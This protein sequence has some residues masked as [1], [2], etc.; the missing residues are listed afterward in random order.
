VSLADVL[1]LVRPSPKDKTR[2]ALYAWIRGATVQD[3]ERLVQKIRYKD[4]QTQEFVEKDRVHSFDDLPQRLK[5][6]EM[7]KSDPSGF[8]SPPK[9]PFQMLTSLDLGVEEWE[10]IAKNMSW[11]ELRQN[12]NT[13]QRH[14]VLANPRMSE[15]VCAKLSSSEEIL[16]AKCFPYQLLV[17]YLNTGPSPK[18]FG[19]TANYWQNAEADKGK[20]AD[21]ITV[22]KEV[23]YALE[24]AL[25]LA[26]KNVPT[27]DGKVFVCPDT[28]GSMGYPVTGDRGYYGKP[29][30]TK[31]RCVDVAG[32]MTAAILRRNPTAAA[33]PFNTRVHDIELNPMD[34]VM[35]NAARFSSL[36]G[37]GTACSEPLR[38]LNSLNAIG[39]VVIFVSDYESWAD[40]K[41]GSG[42]AMMQE[43]NRFKVRNPKAK[44][45]CVDITPHDNRQLLSHPDIM[46]VGGFSDQVFTMIDRFVKG[47][48]SA[49]HWT[50]EIKKIEV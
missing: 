40:T 3:G 44:L 25:E 7:Y 10:T 50:T 24:A 46:Y 16:K 39:D 11:Q 41:T 31:V 35:R 17:A 21:R 6:W 8:G 13:L 2:S 38:V 27:I 15:Y 32:L 4:R 22:P 36:G 19:W 45:V 34:S 30:S 26:V 48:L 28:S 33:L 43:W 12:L 1:R 20:D 23:R 18:G 49:N 42:T 9:V 47:E 14:G 37:G 29:P 5:L